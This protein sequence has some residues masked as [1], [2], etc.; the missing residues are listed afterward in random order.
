[1]RGSV[2][3]AEYKH[4]VLGSAAGS[5]SSGRL[6]IPRTRTTSLRMMG[7][8]SAELALEIYAKKMDRTR[9]TGARMDKLIRGADWTDE[10]A[11]KGANGSGTLETVATL[12][13]KSPAGAGLS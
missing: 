8:E 7:H 9:D 10:K 12:A 4:L 2:E 1:M 13:N 11:Q 6:A 3:S 5:G